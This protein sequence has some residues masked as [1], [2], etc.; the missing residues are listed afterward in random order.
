MHGVNGSMRT[1]VTIKSCGHAATCTCTQNVLHINPVLFS[2]DVSGAGKATISLD[3]WVRRWG[4]RGWSHLDLGRAPG[5]PQAN[6][7]LWADGHV[8]WEGVLQ[9]LGLARERAQEGT[10]PRQA[11][12]GDRGAVGG[13][14]CDAK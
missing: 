5:R 11:T 4:L 12:E 14:V 6:S 10:R 1:E 8:S 7:R 2:P 3:L 13:C 9:G